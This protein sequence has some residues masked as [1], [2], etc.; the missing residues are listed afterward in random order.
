MNDQTTR[1]ADIRADLEDGIDA[2]DAVWLLPLAEQLQGQLDEARAENA[3]LA[4]QDR[5]SGPNTPAPY[6][7]EGTAP[8]SPHE[9]AQGTAPLTLAQAV[10]HLH[11]WARD[12][13]DGTRTD[14]PAGHPDI[15]RGIRAAA[16]W[17]DARDRYEREVREQQA[18]AEREAPVD[19]RAIAERRE[20]E[21]KDA[22]TELHQLRAIERNSS[23]YLCPNCNQWAP[24]TDGTLA[25]DVGED[26]FWCQ[27]CAAETPL[28]AMTSRT[29]EEAPEPAEP[30]W[31]DVIRAMRAAG[32]RLAK[33]E[34]ISAHW[35]HRSLV[36]RGVE[37]GDMTINHI[38]DRWVNLYGRRDGWTFE[39]K[40]PTPAEVLAAARLAG[41]I[42]DTDG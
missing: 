11:D 31:R 30:T 22:K 26:W 27:T 32:Y 6:T 2:D 3:R 41:L 25:A 28:S 37:A 20:R 7:G 42:G 23:E 35:S 12:L 13:D 33:T 39:M 29:A 18:A 21:L 1:L 4:A 15:I 19:W 38:G 17:L 34:R 14:W 9:P 16:D 8:T 5:A 40:N 36:D 10:G 24:W